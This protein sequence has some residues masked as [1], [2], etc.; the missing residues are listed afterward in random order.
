MALGAV[1]ML[2]GVNGGRS[3]ELSGSVGVGDSSSSGGF[4]LPTIPG[5][6]SDLPFQLTASEN[7]S[8][9]SN[10]FATPNG[11]KRSWAAPRR[12]HLDLFGRLVDQG[13]LVWPA[14]LL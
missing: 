1:L 5:N 3:D 12:F 8:Y 11:V 9:N 4:V 6:W 14:I 13:L 10:I 7:V 2:G